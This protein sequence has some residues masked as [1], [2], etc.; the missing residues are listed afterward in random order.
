MRVGYIQFRP[1]FGDA[2]ANL[3]TMKRL[4]AS[5]EADLLVLPELATTGYTFTSKEELARIA[6]P[7]ESSPSLDSLQALAR[8]RDC[9]LVVGFG[10]SDGD[11][12]Y[13]SSALLTPEGDRKLYRKIHLFGAENLFF[14][15]G[16]IPFAVHE[17]RGVKLGMMICFDWFFPESMR[18][19]ALK[20]AQ[21]VCH[22]VNFVLPWGPKAM[23]VR[24]LENRVFSITANRY[25]T[26]ARG[27]YSFSFIGMSQIVSPMGE[28]LAGAPSEGDSVAVV[29]I[30][31]ALALNKRLNKF[32][33]LFASRRPEFYSEIT[34]NID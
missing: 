2:A 13:N 15:P 22:P 24:S 14:A 30:D 17:F 16:E 27:E 6:E 33:D 34:E 1:V 29:E 12:L 26:E 7:F 19:L 8:E 4:I 5:V 3:E 31:P 28:V 23:T 10:E 25:G 21:I 9:A 32:N 11:R 18:T 20:G